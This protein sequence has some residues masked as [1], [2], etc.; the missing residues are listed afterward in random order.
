MGFAKDHLDLEPLEAV[1]SADKKAAL[2]VDYETNVAAIKVHG[3]H[4]AGRIL[5]SPM[6]VRKT[7]TGVSIQT[8]DAWFGEIRLTCVTIEEVR[9]LEA[10]QHRTGS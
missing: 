10:R 4:L 5:R 3:A 8:A 1:V 6:T 2:V 7:N 9:E